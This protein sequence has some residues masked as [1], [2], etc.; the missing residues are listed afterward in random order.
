VLEGS[1][2]L[3]K[4]GI[5]KGAYVLSDAPNGQPAAQILASGSEVQLA[6]AAQKLLAAEGVHVRVVSMPSIELFEKQEQAYKDSVILPNVKKRLAVEMANPVFWYK[7][8]GSEGDV[9]GIE[10][11]GASAPA[12]KILQEYGFTPEN[13]AAKVKALLK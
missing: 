6:V 7:Y 1:A 13:V 2:E 3:A 8:V 9:L 11:F 12:G 4:E 5:R 10:T